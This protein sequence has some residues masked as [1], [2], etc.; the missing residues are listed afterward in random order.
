MAR[1]LTPRVALF[2]TYKQHS[3]SLNTWQVY[4]NVDS[5]LLIARTSGTLLHTKS[6]KGVL[7]MTDVAVENA[8]KRVLDLDARILEIQNQINRLS[9]SLIEIRNERDRAYTFIATWAEFAGVE[10]EAV[11]ELD[12]EPQTKLEATS[13][14]SKMK[15]LKNPKKEDVASKARELILAHGKPMGRSELFKALSDAGITLQGKNPEMVLS[16]MLWRMSNEIVR[17]QPYGYWPADVANT[18]FDYDPEAYSNA[19]NVP[20]TSLDELLG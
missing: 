4:L 7:K 11:A 8:R 3:L 19:S 6:E 1:G 13:R 12:D 2:R 10:I 9:D 16:T 5:T 14:T 18:E 20:D 17:L 15:R